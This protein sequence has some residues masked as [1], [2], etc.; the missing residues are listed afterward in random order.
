MVKAISI[1]RYKKVINSAYKTDFEHIENDHEKRGLGIS[2]CVNHT[3]SIISADNAKIFKVVNGKN[4]IGLFSGVFKN[5]ICV[6]QF[7]FINKDSRHKEGVLL[8]W[9]NVRD[10]FKDTFYTGVLE[11]NKKALTHLIKQGFLEINKIDNK[12]IIKCQ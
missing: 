10:Y 11:S 8:F 2:E 4:E 3:W 1:K 9:K 7:W 6:L 5:S 12:I